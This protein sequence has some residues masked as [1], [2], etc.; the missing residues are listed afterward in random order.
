MLGIRR[1]RSVMPATNASAA[2]GSRASWPPA[3]SHLCDGAG[4]SVKAMPPNPAASAARTNRVNPAPATKSG[5]YGCWT[6][7]YVTQCC[8]AGPR[9]AQLVGGPLEQ[10]RREQRPPDEQPGLGP[11]QAIG[12]AFEAVG[13]A[14][15]RR[16]QSSL[17]EELGAPLRRRPGVVDIR[18]A[19]P[20]HQC[21]DIERAGLVVG[22]AGHELVAARAVGTHPPFHRRHELRRVLV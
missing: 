22:Q 1:I 10:L 14:P 12:L 13:V 5:L 17:R 21:R 8:M 4:W 15:W 6:S 9:S 3:V 18:G 11:A 7:G 2:N 20:E 16:V 19:A